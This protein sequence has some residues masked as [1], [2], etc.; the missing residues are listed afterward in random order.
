MGRY[1]DGDIEGKFWFAI[2]SSDDGEFFGAEPQET[3]YIPYYLSKENFEKTKGIEICRKALDFK[4]K[5]KD[6][7]WYDLHFEWEDCLEKWQKTHNFKNNNYLPYKSF[8]EW[9]KE[10]YNIGDG[11]VDTLSREDFIP[12]WNG[13]MY[14]IHEWI[15]RMYLGEKMQSFFDKNPNTDELF[16]QA[17]L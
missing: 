5:N 6:Y 11:D 10:T 4:I 1:Y 7:N 9:L 8:P 12:E 2:Q 17:E 14:D 3:D 13:G 16:Y 15:A